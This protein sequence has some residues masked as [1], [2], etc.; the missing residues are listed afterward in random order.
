MHVWRAGVVLVAAFMLSMGALASKAEAD[1]VAGPM[2]PS[3]MAGHGTV[4]DAAYAA[5]DAALAAYQAALDA[6]DVLRSVPCLCGCIEGFGHTSNL[7]CYITA[8]YADVTQYSTHG[9]YCLV[10]QRITADALA[11]AARGLNAAQLR[12]MIEEAYGR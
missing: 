1:N 10:C 6:P 2:P 3:V 8:D 7:D 5:G 11:G 4:P 9:L 12:A